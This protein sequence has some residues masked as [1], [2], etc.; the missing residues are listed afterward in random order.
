MEIS[1]NFKIRL[2]T[3]LV[4]LPPV[5]GCVVWGGYAFFL[6]LCVASLMMAREWHTVTGHGGVLPTVA[7]VAAIAVAAYGLLGLLGSMP[8][9]AGY[10]MMFVV[11]VCLTAAFAVSAWL[12]WHFDQTAFWWLTGSLYIAAAMIS[13]L[14]LRSLADGMTIVIWLLFAVWGADVGGY[15][16][17]KSIGG[18]KLAPGISPGKTWAGFAG[19]LVLSASLSALIAYIANWWDPLAVA[20]ASLALATISQIGDLFE[21]ALKRHFHLKDSGGIIPGH[22]GI[23]DRVDGLLFAAPICALMLVWLFLYGGALAP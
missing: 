2:L 17:G 11:L 16:A 12:S 23:L 13:V 6:L 20:V 22:G 7:T 1:R 21:S 14:W 9:R 3:A 5:L 4:L 15:F 8:S 19:G 18:A 10:E